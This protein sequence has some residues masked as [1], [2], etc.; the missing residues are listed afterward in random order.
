MKPLTYEEREKYTAVEAANSLNLTQK[1]NRLMTVGYKP[2][3]GICILPAEKKETFK[4]K[5]EP[6]KEIRFY[7]AMVKSKWWQF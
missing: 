4:A 1:V 2:V 3:G 6:S 5:L 7:Q